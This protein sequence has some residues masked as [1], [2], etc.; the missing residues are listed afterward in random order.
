MHDEHYKRLFAF[1]RVVEDLIR[2]FA[3]AVDAD[4]VDFSTLQKLPAEYITEA[5]R[6]RRG[7]TVWRMRRR[8]DD[9]SA[10]KHRLPPILP[11]VLYN[12]D[13]PW[14]SPTDLEELVAPVD[15]RLAPYQLSQRYIV[16]D[17]RH[18]P[19]D[20][21]PLPRENLMSAVIGL[22]QSSS[23]EDV[24]QETA[25]L[26]QTLRNDTELA[27]VF[28]AWIRH[29]LTPLLPPGSR[30]KATT[31]R[32]LKMTLQERIAEWPK[33]WIQQG[34]QQGRA[35]ERVAVV[36]RL[37]AM[38]FDTATAELAEPLLAQ[39]EESEQVAAGEWLLKT[40]DAADFLAQL[41]QHAPNTEVTAPS[42]T[43]ES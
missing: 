43:E 27:K 10:A 8:T 35:E 40:D 11:I 5:H 31:L 30:P 32:E 34:I 6:A 37:T 28:S 20:D 16:L 4:S 2:E 38:K 29:M 13:P 26:E 36:T 41:Q 18:A 33:Q 9:S 1:P 25:W 42:G 19:R 21:L 22:E 23:A 17:E 14:R 3:P 12:G 24:F 7:D 15:A 39:L